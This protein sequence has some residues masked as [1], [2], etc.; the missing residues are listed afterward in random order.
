MIVAKIVARKDDFLV[1][2]T[3]H[4][5]REFGEREAVQVCASVTTLVYGLYDRHGGKWDYVGDGTGPGSGYTLAVVPL[6]AR[7]EVEFVRHVL[8]LLVENYP[9]H[10]EL[11][12]GE[13]A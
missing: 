1:E 8:R 9:E 7:C 3:G 2:T 12:E 5:N 4:S 10:I 6:R 11:F 13:E